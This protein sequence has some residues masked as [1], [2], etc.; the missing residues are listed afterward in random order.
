LPHVQTTFARSIVLPDGSIQDRAPRICHPGGDVGYPVFTEFGAD[1][2][3]VFVR[4][5]F[6]LDVWFGPNRD[7]DVAQ[8]FVSRKTRDG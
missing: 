4:A 8:V 5:G 6:D 7:E 2:Q 3:D 1:I